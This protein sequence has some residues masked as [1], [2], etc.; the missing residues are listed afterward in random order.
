M[1]IQQKQRLFYKIIKHLNKK[2]C[3][4]KILINEIVPFRKG[5]LH[6]SFPDNHGFYFNKKKM[7]L[8]MEAE[9]LVMQIVILVHE[10]VHA[11]QH[12]ILR[13]KGKLKHDRIG[14][15]I[16]QQFLEEIDKIVK[17]SM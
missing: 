17:V 16:N 4:N 8:I 1:N 5:E 15:K 7:I 9:P 12:Q 3:K 10:F 2:F 14:R 11:Y 6:K 13:Y